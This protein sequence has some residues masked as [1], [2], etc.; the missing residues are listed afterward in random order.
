M[1]ITGKLDVEFFNFEYD[2]SLDESID[3]DKYLRV[4]KVWNIYYHGFMDKFCDIAYVKTPTT[5]EPGIYEITTYGI[6]AYL[7][8]WKYGDDHPRGLKGLIVKVGDTDL[9]KDAFEKYATTQYFV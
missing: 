3:R 4:D 2:R 6:P 7:F 5:I 8:V 1:E 9:I